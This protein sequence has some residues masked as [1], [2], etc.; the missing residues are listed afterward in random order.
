LPTIHPEPFNP[1]LTFHGRIVNSDSTSQV[2]A[3]H[4]TS[5]LLLTGANRYA[6]NLFQMF[7]AARVA[8]AFLA[9][10]SIAYVL[11]TPDPTDDATGLVRPSHL[12]KA[13]KLAVSF[14]QL[15]TQQSVVFLLPTPLSSTQRLTTL[16]LF[17]SYRC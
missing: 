10:F 2:G 5:R 8:L 7:R 3:D 6:I 17:C 12:S 4:L 1:S 9:I 13:Q 11:V 15:T 14:I 16:D